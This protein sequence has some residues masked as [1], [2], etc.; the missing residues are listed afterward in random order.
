MEDTLVKLLP[1]LGVGGAAVAGMVFIVNRF[2][3][4]I[5]GKDKSF[6]N[7]IENHLKH[8]NEAL[9]NLVQ[10]TKTVSAAIVRMEKKKRSM[11][12]AIIEEV[13]K[14]KKK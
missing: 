8:H 5:D 2:I 9:A 14:L 1:Q 3:K 6:V 10:E 7:I 13:K 12:A 11:T 4:H